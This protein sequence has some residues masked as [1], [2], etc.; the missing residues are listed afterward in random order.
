MDE[1][2]RRAITK[3]TTGLKFCNGCEEWRSKGEF[4]KDNKSKDGLSYRCRSCRKKYRREDEVK[5]RTSVYNKKYADK[6]PDLMKAKDRKNSL[7]RF[8]N[9]TVEQFEE[10]KAAQGE[11]CALCPKTESNPHKALCID[12]CH[13]TGKIRGLL[14]DNHNRAMGLFKDSIEDMEK[15]INYLKSYR[16]VG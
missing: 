16:S 9:M 1:N 6:K 8:W 5:A 2:V 11:T 7:K 10:M 4:N 12:R 14:C 13:E 15:A 3:E